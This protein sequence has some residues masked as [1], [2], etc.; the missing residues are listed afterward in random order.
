M[1]IRPILS[2]ML[3][4]K[5]GATLVAAQIA[6]TLAIIVNSAF[7]AYERFRVINRPT[8]MD[9]PN[10]I[11][12]G[13]QRIDDATDMREVSEEDMRKLQNIPGV[14]AVTATNAVPLS[15]GGWGEGIQLEDNDESPITSAG[16]YMMNE[17]AV[18]TL[19]IRI[20]DGRNF[21]HDEMIY[22]QQNDNQSPDVVLITEATSKALSPDES[23]LGKTVFLDSKPI[24]VVGIIEHMHGSWVGWDGLDRVAIM[25]GMMLTPYNRYLIRTEPEMRDTVMADLEQTLLDAYPRRI[26]GTPRTLAEYSERSYSNDYTIAVIMLIVIALLIVITALGIVGLVSFLVNQRTKQVGTRRAL[27]AQKH[28]VVRYFLVENWLITT[29]GLSVG[30]VL[31]V[32]LNMY[33]VEHFEMPKLGDGFLPVGLIAIWVLGLLAALGPARKAARVSPAVATRTV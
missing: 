13:W 1:E 9:T 26:I 21:T 10:I 4:N 16:M 8:G 11:A 33:L 17:Q 30:I 5:L 6:F 29:I 14:I 27:G 24:K 22:R 18:Q 25:P 23:L 3:R 31:T 20:K 19:G 15:N 32:L 12:V 7:I 2:A 28:H